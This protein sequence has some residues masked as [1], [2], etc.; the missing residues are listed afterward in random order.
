MLVALLAV[1]LLA[2]VAPVAQRVLR[3]SAGWVFALP[4]LSVTAWL[5]SLVPRVSGGDVVLQQ[6]EWIPAL[7]LDLSFR[8]DGW[9]LLFL[10]LISG[11]GALI[12]VYAAGYFGDHP[13]A[14]RFYALL[15][16]FMGSMLGVVAADNLLLLFVFW[17]LTS[18]TSYLL[19][20]F[21]HE[22]PESRAAALQALLVTGAGGL[23]LLAGV[24]LIGEAGGTFSLTELLR[25]D[26]PL[27][28]HALYLPI[29]LLVLTGA[30]TKSA[31][32]P[33]HFWLP[34]AMAAPTPVSAYLHSATMVTAGV[35]LLG[36]LHPLLGGTAAWHGIVTAVGAVTMVTGAVM[37]MPQTDLKRLLAFSTISA[38][39]IL[40]MLL[41]IG[42]SLATQAAVVFLIVHSL[43]KGALFMVA[44]AVDHDAGTRDVRELSGLFRVMPITAAAA[45]LAA[46]SMSGLPP[47][48]G[49]IGKELLYE[50]GLGAPRGALSITAA[51]VTANVLM[52]A[53]AAIV[54]VRPF[55]GG[56]TRA[57]T[58]TGEPALALWL[59]PV[60][61]ASLALVAGVVPA[62]VDQPLVSAA[63]TAIRSE[64]TTVA[65]GL[66]HGV[67]TALLLSVATVLTGVMAYRGRERIRVLAPPLDVLTQLGPTALF[68]AGLR[69]LVRVA[70]W[71]TRLLQHGYLRGY[72]LSILAVAT[73]LTGFALLRFGAVPLW[74]GV[75]NLRAYEVAIA[76]VILGAALVAATA[77]SRLAAVAAMG[78]V[79][80]G[81]ALIYGL[82]GAPDLAVTQILVETLT[83][84][85]FVLVVVNL[86]AFAQLSSPRRR[87]FDAAFA[88][89]AGV[90]ITGLVLKAL[91]VEHGDRVSD[92]YVTNALV[93]QGRNVVNIILV[94][95]RSLDTLGEIAVL[96]V[97]ALGVV[98][99]LKLRPP[100]DRGEE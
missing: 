9:S 75:G 33:F 52:V 83:L 82:Y 23:A 44:G 61:L 35:F 3:R 62:L 87:R 48:L 13:Q 22:K 57:G 98:A 16:L 40:T 8:V 93:A 41:G 91:H 51:S 81:V 31:Q 37:A 94:D 4:I 95:F 29:L 2:L 88:G 1:F 77:R 42:T 49:F 12:L 89:G 30:F 17:E 53:V 69:L 20:G 10:L 25:R 99:M 56:R 15:L 59:G 5:A 96:T 47:L 100:A 26:D 19:I 43:Y 24:I 27:R 92:Y 45:G 85:L 73:A 66:W 39:G 80:Y 70:E 6:R 38:L 97:A 65:L 79:G 74:V 32:T 86:P 36:R 76:V 11:I 54:G 90:V 18:I 58:A 84:V 71:Q 7:G 46:L 68:A 78:T 63:V 64:P 60:V 55:I 14:G 34:G 21:D 67:N 28:Q 72:V 50:A